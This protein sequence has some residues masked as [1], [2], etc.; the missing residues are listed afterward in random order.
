[1]AE[2]RPYDAVYESAMLSISGEQQRALNDR[3]ADLRAQA[4]DAVTKSRKLRAQC[5]TLR[6]IMADARARRDHPAPA[7]PRGGGTRPKPA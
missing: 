3:S 1:M 5:A 7:R 4:A 6:E 2:D